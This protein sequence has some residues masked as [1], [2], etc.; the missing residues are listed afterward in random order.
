LED[1]IWIAIA[2]VAGLF[3][4][5]NKVNKQR[6]ERQG[7]G[8][9]QAPPQQWPGPVAGPKPGQGPTWGPAPRPQGSGSTWAPSPAPRPGFGQPK[10]AEAPAPKKEQPKTL[11]SGDVFT[12]S[13]E[14]EGYGTEGVGTEGVGVEGPG[15]GEGVE[16]EV[17][18]FS[19]ESESMEKRELAELSDDLV[20]PERG[21]YS[22]APEAVGAADLQSTLTDSSGLMRAIVLSEVMGK[23]KAL[24]GRGAR[25][26]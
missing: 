2:L 16:D 5:A 9:S 4:L 12:R 25:R 22:L 3:S 13:L 7:G 8:P 20:R 11:V 24:R 10:P 17:Y 1:F 18:R 26:L 23:P 19:R 15:V 21:A 6:Q 14:S